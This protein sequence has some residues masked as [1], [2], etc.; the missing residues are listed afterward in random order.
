MKYTFEKELR[1]ARI[2]KRNS[3]FTMNIDVDGEVIKAHCPATTR[4][5]DVDLAGVA[6]LVSKSDDP[7]RKLK[8]TVEAVS[9]DNPETKDKN[10]IG[11]NLILSN[12]IVEFLLNTHQLDEMVYD[13][14]EVKREVFLGSSK[15][16]FLVGNTYLE[17]KTPLTTVNVRYGDKIK[18]KKVTPFSS[19]DRMVRHVGELAYSL[20]DHER[21]ILLT[22]QQYE[23]TEVKPHMHSTHYEEVKAAMTEAVEKGVESW[24]I[25]LK[26]TPT[27]VSLLKLTNTTRDLLSY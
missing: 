5:G 6:C 12:R 25:S 19:T 27:G 2:V 22:V 11:I 7:K 20:K 24:N 9:F 3:Q 14:V 13:Y 17:V 21:A 4:I 26:F 10:W 8:Y 18:T 15:L 16:D 23:E 1:E